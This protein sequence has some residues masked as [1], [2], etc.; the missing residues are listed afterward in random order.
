MNPLIY[1]SISL[2][3]EVSNSEMYGGKDS[4][5][6][7]ALNFGGVGNLEKVDDDFINKQ[8]ENIANTLHVSKE[9][10]KL[11]SKEEYDFETEEDDEGES[12]EL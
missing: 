10:I 3:F 6:Y 4:I 8:I 2:H 5:G 1:V 9:D 7:A 11:I 12:D